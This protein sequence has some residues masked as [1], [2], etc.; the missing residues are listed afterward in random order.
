MGSWITEKRGLS[1]V[2]PSY[3]SVRYCDG[4]IG[5]LVKTQSVGLCHDD[6]YAR[7][8]RN[9]SRIRHCECSGRDGISDQFAEESKTMNDDWKTIESNLQFV[10]DE[11][12]AQPEVAV[13][14]PPN[15]LSYDEELEQV[16]EWLVDVG[17]VGIAYESIVAMLERLPIHLSGL[18]SVKL[19]EAALLMGFKTD[20]PQDARF[21]KR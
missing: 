1:P 7:W 17:E 11:L 6:S 5:Y 14:I 4:P 12:L 9:Q 19:L 8:S 10:F 20:R 16:R 21:D 3:S 18:A 15:M 13:H 2:I